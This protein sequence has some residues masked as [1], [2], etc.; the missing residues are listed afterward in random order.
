MS[1]HGSYRAPHD[2]RPQITVDC[3]DAA[4]KSLLASFGLVAIDFAVGEPGHERVVL[5]VTKPGTFT[6]PEVVKAGMPISV[7]PSLD[8]PSGVEI[9]LSIRWDRP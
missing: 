4:M 2:S 1:F 8:N 6:L 3:Q 7:R 9:R 5:K